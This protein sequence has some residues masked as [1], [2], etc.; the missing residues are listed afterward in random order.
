MKSN[1]TTIPVEAKA[2]V[3]IKTKIAGKFALDVNVGISNPT[4]IRI[5]N[6]RNN[7][8]T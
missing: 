8:I 4:N 1:L 7:K 5:H 3:S 2:K 6:D